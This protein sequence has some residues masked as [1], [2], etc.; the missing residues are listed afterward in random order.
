MVLRVCGELPMLNITGRQGVWYVTWCVE[1]Y[2]RLKRMV[3][4]VCGELPTLRIGSAKG[5]W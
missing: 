2:Q 1:S 5:L 3:L 4:R